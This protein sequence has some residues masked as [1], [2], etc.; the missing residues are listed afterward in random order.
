MQPNSILMA[1]VE[2][3]QAQRQARARAEQRASSPRNSRG[4]VAALISR[5]WRR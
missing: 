2:I 3:D 5:L 4:P 1:N